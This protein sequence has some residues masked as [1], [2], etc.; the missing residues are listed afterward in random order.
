MKSTK[1]AII[2]TIG[3]QVIKHSKLITLVYEIANLLNERPIGK[4]SNDIDDGT[5]LCPN[6]LLLGRATS[7]APSGPFRETSNPR[8]RFAFIQMLTDAFWVK[9]NKFYFPSL[10]I[11]Q[12]W[13]T[14]ARNVTIG[15]IVLLQDSN[16][17]RGSWGLAKVL[18]V[19]PSDDRTVRKVLIGYKNVDDI[20]RQTVGKGRTSST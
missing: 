9:W 18:N 8:K 11:Q 5:Y 2:S 4:Q 16:A 10:L 12:K 13:H 19:F 1:K 7:R 20:Q 6:D 14:T 15:D 17:I 3:H